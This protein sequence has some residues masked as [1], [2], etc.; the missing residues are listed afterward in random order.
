MVI[1]SYQERI[2]AFGAKFVIIIKG[3]ATSLKKIT[4]TEQKLQL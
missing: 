1:K 3:I 2:S 4:A